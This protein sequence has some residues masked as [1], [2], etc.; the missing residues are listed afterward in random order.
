M[1]IGYKIMDLVFSTLVPD[2][3]AEKKKKFSTKRI[4]RK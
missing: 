4:Q 3:S 1:K 2:T